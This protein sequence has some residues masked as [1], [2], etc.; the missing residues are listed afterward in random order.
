M[1]I[2]LITCICLTT[3][4]IQAQHYFAISFKDDASRLIGFKN[5]QGE[6]IWPAQFEQ[7]DVLY[8]NPVER[9][10]AYV[11]VK[12]KGKYGLISLSTGQMTVPCEYSALEN[13]CYVSDNRLLAVKDGKKGMINFQ[14]EVLLPAIYDGISEEIHGPFYRAVL[15]QKTA[16]FDRQFRQIVPPIYDEV[17]VKHPSSQMSHSVSGRLFFQTRLNGKYGLLDASGKELLPNKYLEIEVS[18]VDPTCGNTAIYFTV[19]SEI[20]QKGVVAATGRIIELKLKGVVDATD[21]VIVPLVFEYIHFMHAGEDSCDATGAIYAIAESTKHDYRLFNLRTGASS[22]KLDGIFPFDNQLIFK[23][24]TNWGSMDT[25]FRVHV[26]GK[27]GIPQP[28]TPYVTYKKVAQ[29]AIERSQV[30]LLAELHRD[31]ETER[32]AEEVRMVYSYGLHDF[33]TGNT[34]PMRFDRVLLKTDST[35]FYYW[36]IRFEPGS[37]KQRGEITICDTTLHPIRK[38]AF[39]DEFLLE[40]ELR[41]DST[42]YLRRYKNNVRETPCHG[43]L[44]IFGDASGRYGAVNVKGETVVPFLYAAGAVRMIQTKEWEMFYEFNSPNGFALYDANGRLC[45]ADY[46]SLEYVKEHYIVESAS[47]WRLL[48]RDFQVVNKGFEKMRIFRFEAYHELQKYNFAGI[49][50]NYFYVFD[51]EHFTKLDESQIPFN[52]AHPLQHFYPYPYLFDRTA[53]IVAEG[54]I[55]FLGSPLYAVLD[56]G[57]LS[58][59]DE[60]GRKIL[61]SDGVTYVSDYEYTYLKVFL[62]NGKEGMIAKSTGSW[63]VNPYVDSP[64]PVKDPK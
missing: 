35:A 21:K 62:H 20:K 33:M 3:S 42:G 40:H 52:A 34:L 44:I 5:Q 41:P 25:N 31:Q 50:D 45:A 22:K 23:G 1:K 47:G 7:E 63:F 59:V 37:L 29:P 19:C 43:R 2:L 17:L 55:T 11:R 61:E 51:G 10:N 60:T 6:I 36:C 27:R 15:N 57:H 46:T 12:R 53:R 30:I 56:N 38:L 54:Q 48:N 9:K 64:V 18:P 13:I 26:S 14:H 32:K 49:L 16:I 24:K 8:E 39:A 4:L 28:L 58:I